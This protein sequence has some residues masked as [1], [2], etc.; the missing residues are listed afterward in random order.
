MA[1]F[2]AFRANGD[3]AAE[4][5]RRAREVL[6][7]APNYAHPRYWAGFAVHGGDGSP[8]SPSDLRWYLALAGGVLLVV[9]VSRSLR[10]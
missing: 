2:H 6:A 4:A 5:M 3:D 1:Q 10:R 8:A 7:A 9:V